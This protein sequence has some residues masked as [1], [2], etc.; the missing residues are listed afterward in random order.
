MKSPAVEKGSFL[1]EK[2]GQ[3]VEFKIDK[4][5]NERFVDFVEILIKIYFFHESDTAKTDDF[6]RSFLENLL[7][8]KCEFENL[9]KSLV[10]AVSFSL[11]FFFPFS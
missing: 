1:H 10:F 11:L 5:K 8:S 7:S 4:K 9:P 6:D 2:N 3:I